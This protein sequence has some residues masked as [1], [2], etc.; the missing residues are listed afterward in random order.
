MSVS[1]FVCN[2]FGMFWNNI[3]TFSWLFQL[4]QKF[5][6]CE[7]KKIWEMLQI[8]ILFCNYINQYVVE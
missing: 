4:C 6:L 3:L 2:L 8:L 5:D 7:I 1:K